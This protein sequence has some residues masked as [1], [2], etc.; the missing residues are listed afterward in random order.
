[1]E[2]LIKPEFGLMFWTISIFAV[3]V[4]LL[5]RTAWKPLM[6]AVEERERALHRDKAAAEQA[7][8]DAEKIKLELDSR[9][10]ALKAEAE[11]RLASASAQGLREKD[12]IIDEARKSAALLVEAA[13]KELEAGRNELA[14]DL[15]NKVAELSL[16]AA[17]KVLLKNVDQKANKELVDR[18]LKE[19][20]AKDAKYRLGN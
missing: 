1:M 5:S 17:E 9:L 18:F 14:R 16:L 8:A 19:L 11:A 6:K 10:A 3:L 20:E 13:K 2:A 7:R 12:Q 15:K 4:V